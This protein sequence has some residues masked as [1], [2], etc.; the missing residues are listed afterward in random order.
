MNRQA[1]IA[2]SAL[3]LVAVSAPAHATFNPGYDR[4]ILSAEVKVTQA[5]GDF[6]ELENV[7][8]V[9]A[10]R[11]GAKN[12]VT[13]TFE[14]NGQEPIKFVKISTE[15][16]G[17]GSIKHTAI[18]IESLLDND[19]RGYTLTLVDHSRRICEDYRPGLWDV[20]IS[21]MGSMLPIAEEAT[22][23]SGYGNPELVF[24]IQ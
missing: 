9:E 1:L 3:A 8:I 23:L 18:D 11:D 10:H 13:Y 5:T 4:P 19:K 6:R 22:V 20:T 14:A 16:A 15:D 12:V 24:S 2:L 7:T 17:C 21:K